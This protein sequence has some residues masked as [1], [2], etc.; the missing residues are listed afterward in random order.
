[1]HPVTHSTEAEI[2]MANPGGYL[3]PGMFVTVDIFYGESEQATL[4]PLSALYENPITGATG[5]YV[6]NAVLDREP[7]GKLSSDQSIAFTDPV[8]F[9][10]VAV[11]VIA[12]GRME[13]GI[14]GVN[15]DDWVVTLGQNLLGGESGTARVRPVR[16]DWVEEL[17]NLQ[18]DDLMQDL[19]ERQ[20][21]V[22]DTISGN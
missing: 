18:R 15:E 11:D 21:A 6:S 12:K 4:V 17:Q 22:N 7:V 16:W 9:E 5:V 10:F 14:R 19:I 13:A 2:D 3:K 20:Q 8:T 1:L